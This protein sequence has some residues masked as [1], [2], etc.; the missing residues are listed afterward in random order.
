[1]VHKSQERTMLRNLYKNQLS[2]E[3]RKESTSYPPNSQTDDPYVSDKSATM[4]KLCKVLTYFFA[5]GVLLNGFFIKLP[6][7]DNSS[8]KAI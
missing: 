1:M 8:Q 2:L 5:S 6:L 4:N 3:L 7:Y